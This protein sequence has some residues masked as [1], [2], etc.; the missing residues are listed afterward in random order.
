MNTH[1]L[2]LVMVGLVVA[3][4]TTFLVVNLRY[5]PDHRGSEEEEDD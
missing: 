4:W 1:V 3:S 5:Q 2:D